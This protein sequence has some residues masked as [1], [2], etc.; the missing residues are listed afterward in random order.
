[1]KERCIGDQDGAHQARCVCLLAAPYRI[2]IANMLAVASWWDDLAVRNPR[3]AEDRGTEKASLKNITNSF[4]QLV[5]WFPSSFLSHSLFCFIIPQKC[6]HGISY[7]VMTP[8]GGIF[9][10]QS[11]AN[12]RRRLGDWLFVGEKERKRNTRG[13]LISSLSLTH[14]Y[15]HMA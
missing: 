7:Y 14:I 15:P 12:Q 11:S 3:Q 9:V 1:M 4:W 2:C 6:I 13:C 8:A 10:S 5:F